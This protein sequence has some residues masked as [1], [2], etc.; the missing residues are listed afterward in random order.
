M[1]VLLTAGRKNAE[2]AL[3]HYTDDKITD[4]QINW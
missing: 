4:L 1:A 3:F 2:F